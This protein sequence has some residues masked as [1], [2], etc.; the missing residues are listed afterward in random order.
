MSI[1]SAGPFV[2][3]IAVWIF[4][5]DRRRLAR[6]CGEHSQKSSR[7]GTCPPSPLWHSS[8][9]PCGAPEQRRKPRWPRAHR[10]SRSIGSVA[11][12]RNADARA[13]CS[14]SFKQ[15]ERARRATFPGQVEIHLLYFTNR[16][17]WRASPAPDGPGDEPMCGA[18]VK[19]GHQMHR[20]RWRK[21]S[22]ARG[23]PRCIR[24]FCAPMTSRTW[25]HPVE[26]A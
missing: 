7:N 4:L 22:V 23:R 2:Q 9:R 6:Y 21:A 13:A 1:T 24:W 3:E 5:A 18:E 19:P 14:C 25:P 8:S 20:R 12:N 26:N 11:T 17:T 15:V 16:M 10:P